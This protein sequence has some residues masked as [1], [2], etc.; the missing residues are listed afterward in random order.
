MEGVFSGWRRA[1]G[2][3]GSRP[4]RL[5]L[6]LLPRGLLAPSRRRVDPA[7]DD[8][9]WVGEG[10]QLARLITIRVLARSCVALDRRR[11]GF[12]GVAGHQLI[13][14]RRLPGL[15]SD[16]HF[17]VRRPGHPVDDVATVRRNILR[18]GEAL[19]DS[20]HMNCLFRHSASLFCGAGGLARSVPP[21]FVETA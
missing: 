4:S 5:T 8:D 16:F 10:P 21:Q 15:E 7:F 2:R 18:F 12:P 14:E 6:L 1:D 9:Q 13:W 20:D 17:D 19:A 3:L 11:D